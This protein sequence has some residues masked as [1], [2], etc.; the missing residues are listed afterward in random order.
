MK[1]V[2]YPDPTRNHKYFYWKATYDF[3]ISFLNKNPELRS[4]DG[5]YGKWGTS[6]NEN[7]K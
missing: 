4:A 7:E 1:N 6:G 2:I 3:M 5:A